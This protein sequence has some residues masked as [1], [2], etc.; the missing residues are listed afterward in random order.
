[1][2][3]TNNKLPKVDLSN[4]KAQATPIQIILDK[5]RTNIKKY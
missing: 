1:M 2:L 4:I 3:I 5:R